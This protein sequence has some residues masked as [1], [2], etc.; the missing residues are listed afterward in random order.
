[1]MARLSTFSEVPKDADPIDFSWF[2][3]MLVFAE[4]CGKPE[5][6]E[7]IVNLKEILTKFTQEQEKQV[8]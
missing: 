5:V 3:N 4:V 7:R 1:M 8:F 6:Q 2:A